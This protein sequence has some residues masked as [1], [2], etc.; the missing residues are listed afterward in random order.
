MMELEKLIL[1]EV[2][3]PHKDKYCTFPLTCVCCLLNLKQA[4]YNPHNHRDKVSCK[5]MG[6]GKIQ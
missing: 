1:S 6:E 3:E 5:G 4:C 2:T